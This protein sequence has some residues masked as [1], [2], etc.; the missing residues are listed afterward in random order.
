MIS[1]E[2]ELVVTRV[3]NKLGKF[4]QIIILHIYMYILQKK[5]HK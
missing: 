4:L 1:K 2:M 3:I 5:Q